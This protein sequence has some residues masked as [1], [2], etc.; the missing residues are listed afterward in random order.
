MSRGFRDFRV[1][2]E[3]GVL[4]KNSNGCQGHFKVSLEAPQS[5]R[6]S[7]GHLRGFRGVYWNFREY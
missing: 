1:F 4:L 2:Q 5:S 7:Q 3:A 6:M